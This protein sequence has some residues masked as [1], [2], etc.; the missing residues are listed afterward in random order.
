[1]NRTPARKQIPTKQ[2][3][4]LIE[5]LKA[6]FQDNPNRHQ[7]LGWAMVLARLEA[8]PEKLW[9]LQEMER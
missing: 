7:G 8:D 2:R 4:A 9:S 5:T 6:R 3:D 1:M